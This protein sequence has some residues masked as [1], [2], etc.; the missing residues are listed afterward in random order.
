MRLHRVIVGALWC[1][2]T[3]AFAIDLNAA[4]RSDLERMPR[5]GVAKAD[6]ILNERARGGRFVS[7][8]DFRARV[9]GIGPASVDALRAFGVTIEPGANPT[10]SP[11]S[12][13][14]DR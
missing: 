11:E 3:H 2:V 6:V 5:I 10:P 13:G 14:R 7:W 8:D 12:P 1:A 4:D 9:A